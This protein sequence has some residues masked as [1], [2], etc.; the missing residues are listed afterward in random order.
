MEN[1]YIIDAAKITENMNLADEYDTLA[2][3]SCFQ[4]LLNKEE[5]RMFII[6]K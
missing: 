2:L 4:G 6:C 3:I 1:F 5:P